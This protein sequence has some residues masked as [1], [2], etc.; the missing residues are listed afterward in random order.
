MAAY[1]ISLFAVCETDLYLLDSAEN[2]NIL[3]KYKITY[4]QK[5]SN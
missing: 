1:Y 3:K 4:A 2:N 5:V